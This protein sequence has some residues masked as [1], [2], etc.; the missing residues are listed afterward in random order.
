YA[1]L[2]H[3]MPE[4]K[5]SDT[6]KVPHAQPQSFFITVIFT[7]TQFKRLISQTGYLT[8]A[9]SRSLDRATLLCESLSSRGNFSR[10]V[11]S[12]RPSMDFAPSLSGRVQTDQLI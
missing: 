5:I 1:P 10:Q 7:V 9:S 3:V 4:H 8:L 12:S 11:E 6:L 2:T